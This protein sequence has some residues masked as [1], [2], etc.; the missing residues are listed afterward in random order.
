MLIKSDIT[1]KKAEKFTKKF[2]KIYKKERIKETEK[3]MRVFPETYKNIMR[4]HDLIYL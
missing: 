2:D 3:F 1:G 4:V